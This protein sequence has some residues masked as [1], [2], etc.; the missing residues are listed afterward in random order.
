M[1]GRPIDAAALTTGAATN[2]PNA[3]TCVTPSSRI[4][5]R[6]IFLLAAKFLRKRIA[7][8]GLTEGGLAGTGL[9][10]TSASLSIVASIGRCEQTN[11]DLE[12][13]RIS[14]RRSAIARPGL[15][16]PP[17]PPPA[18]ITEGEFGFW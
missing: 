4:T 14:L 18:K 6:T 13:G 8:V 7:P 9:K 16:W 3:T 2:P 10:G 11:I 5:P 17:E 1:I 15:M 12:P